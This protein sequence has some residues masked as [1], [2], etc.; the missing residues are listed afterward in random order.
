MDKVNKDI[1]NIILV[2]DHPLLRKGLKDMLNEEKNFKVIGE[3]GDGNEALELIQELKPDIAIID[4]QMPIMS[5]LELVH[6]LHQQ[7]SKPDF[8]VLTMY[9]KENIFNRAMDLGVKGYIM[10]DSAL[11]EI[12]DAVKNVAAGKFFISSSISDLL[13]KRNIS[14]VSDDDIGI[15]KLS[16]TER[17]ILR[18]IAN[19]MTTKEI[20][21]ELFISN[22]TVNTHR[23]NICSKLNL[24]GTNA[25]LH[26]VLEHKDLI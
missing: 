10:K 26:F 4:I 14:D 22:H 20:A 17:K 21:N 8:I 6:T 15:S 19:N 13:V 2:D 25:L 18:M 7:K 24:K 1:I 12:V 11:T 23:S 5:G 16:M 9:D 3:A